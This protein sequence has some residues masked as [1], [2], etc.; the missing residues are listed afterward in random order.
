MS[1]ILIKNKV[2]FYKQVV[3]SVLILRNILGILSQDLS[4]LRIKKVTI[5]SSEL[6]WSQEYLS[7]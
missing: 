1:T 5:I 3:D 6:S 4:F 2:T 7:H